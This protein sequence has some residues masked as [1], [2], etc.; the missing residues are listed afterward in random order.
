MTT[1]HPFCDPALPFSELRRLDLC[2]FS[3]M[4]ALAKS[5]PAQALLSRE[6]SA[7][8]LALAASG[9][10]AL[11]QASG[12]PASRWLI[13]EDH[14]WSQSLHAPLAL[15]PRLGLSSARAKAAAAL[16][17]AG[18]S[19]WHP[20]WSLI[21]P[22]SCSA[23]P[24]ALPPDGLA[25]VILSGA[26]APLRRLY[27]K[28]ALADPLT[29]PAFAERLEQIYQD[30]VASSCASASGVLGPGDQAAKAI[31]SVIASCEPEMLA[32]ASRPGFEKTAPL[33]AGA[34]ALLALKLQTPAAINP[35]ALKK[36][37][38]EPQKSRL[39][40]LNLLASKQAEDPDL[41]IAGLEASPWIAQQPQLACL[42]INRAP[43]LLASLLRSGCLAPI[44]WLEQR[45]ANLWL[46][47][48]QAGSADAC[49]WT[50]QA[51]GAF[52]RESDLSPIAR[53]LLRGA[54]LGGEADPKARCAALLRQ[55]LDEH[56][57]RCAHD[58]RGLANGRS[59]MAAVESL[60]LEEVIAAAGPA[61]GASTRPKRSL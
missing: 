39:R 31:C 26:D 7:S 12:L 30:R 27:L 14:Q 50:A 29:P 16:A 61:S 23:A 54:W 17:E 6:S 25:G 47:A 32:A 59:V 42:S 18:C 4:M 60:A 44:A 5:S 40:S 48:A 57:R 49:A 20:W 56:E 52:P 34:K 21:Q 11:G 37:L 2:A 58:E 10:I 45:G 36:A 46:A 28:I 53:M 35:E 51:F 22:Q 9:Y 55:A 38:T 24:S 13:W 8:E 3:A 1:P 41:I 19:P 15:F 33:L 43:S